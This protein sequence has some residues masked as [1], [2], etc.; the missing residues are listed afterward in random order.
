MLWL[1]VFLPRLPIE[2][3]QRSLAGAL[4]FAVCDRLTVLYACDAAQALGVH[5]GQKRA[6]A[7]ALAPQLLIVERDPDRERR[8]LEQVAAWALQFTPSVSLPPPTADGSLAVPAANARAA[9]VTTPTRAAGAATGTRTPRAPAAKRAAAAR[10]EPAADPR[11]HGLLLE[12]EPSLRLFGGLE[13]LL[14]RLRDG[15]DE[16]GFDARIGCAAT[17]GAAWLLAQHGSEAPALDERALEARLA[18]LPVRLLEHARP[19]HAVLESLGVRTLGELTRLPRAGIARRFGKTLLEELD[20]ASGRQP[21]PRAWFEA[22]AVFDAKLE[23]LAQIEQA[24]ALLFAARR[25]LAQLGGWLLARHGATRSVLLAAEH[26]EAPA[27]R[28]ELKLAE[29]SRDVARLTAL[30]REQLNVTQLPEPVHTLRL[31][32]DAIESTTIDSG[33]LFPSRTASHEGLGPLVERLQ[34]RL[35]RQRVQRLLLA[36]DHRPETSYRI[37]MVDRLSQLAG[38]GTFGETA[39]LG[40]LPRP[41]WLLR[42]PM[43]LAERANRPYWNGR[44]TLLAGPERIETG[45]WDGSLVQR[46]YFVAED[47]AHTLYWIYRERLPATAHGGGWFLHGKFG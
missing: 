31:H 5:T 16:L 18:S 26:D 35:G 33:E 20:R 2:V 22:P 17:A 45:W 25:L 12:I 7:L 37:A 36:S 46:D 9:G 13:P 14:Q 39:A 3:F 19:H 34:A 29:P 38:H 40:A 41:L 44:L 1:G 43:P 27:T 6:T 11:A 42:E 10:A 8:A 4:P 23:L 21:E 28:I 47:E 30:L 32:C 24:E 15:L